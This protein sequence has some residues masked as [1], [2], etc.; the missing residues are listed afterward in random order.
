[1][2]ARA[3]SDSVLMDFIYALICESRFLGDSAASA[4]S[5]KLVSVASTSS[6]VGGGGC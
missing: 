2:A 5:G 3:A 4:A 6:M 1:M